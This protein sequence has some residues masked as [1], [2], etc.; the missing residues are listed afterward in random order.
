MWWYNTGSQHISRFVPKVLSRSGPYW[1]RGTLWWAENFY[2]QHNGS[3]YCCHFGGRQMYGM[4]WHSYEIRNTKIICSLCLNWG[5]R[6]N[7]GHCPFHDNTRLH[8]AETIKSIFTDYKRK[9]TPLPTYSPGFQ[10]FQKLKE[11]LCSQ[12]VQSLGT[13]NAAVTWHIRQL[14]SS[15]QLYIKITTALGNC[16]EAY[17]AQTVTRHTAAKL[18]WGIQGPPLKFLK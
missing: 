6:K 2:R 18:S 4:W 1:A 10:L 13:M 14:N 11:P 7:N 5:V 16:H 8:T 9:A 15:R 12:W 17:R 3:H